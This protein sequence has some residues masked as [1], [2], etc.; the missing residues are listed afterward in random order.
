MNKKD[1]EKL[2]H[3]NQRLLM[4]LGYSTALIIPNKKHICINKF[5]SKKYKWFMKSLENVVYLDKPLEPAP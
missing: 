2:I 1:I 4:L 3:M 5:E